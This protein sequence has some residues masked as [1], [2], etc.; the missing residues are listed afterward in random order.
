MAS[1]YAGSY[2]GEALEGRL[3]V[4]VS[5]IPTITADTGKVTITSN[6]YAEFPLKTWGGGATFDTN[7]SFDAAPVSVS[8]GSSSNRVT[9]WHLGTRVIEVTP[10]FD[11]PLS[12]AIQGTYTGVSGIGS[13]TV[14]S[15]NAWFSIPRKPY[16]AALP[17]L[18]FQY[19]RSGSSATLNWL[20]N[21]TGADG[22]HP[23]G[24]VRVSRWDNVGGWVDPI[25][26]LGWNAVTWTDTSLAADRAYQYG[27]R[28]EGPGGASAWVTPPTVLYTQPLAPTNVVA[29]K[30]AA[31]D[32]VVSWNS[33]S[34][35]ATRWEV[36][37]AADGV[38]EPDPIAAVTDKSW[39]HQGPSILQTHS[40]RIVALTPDD[41]NAS[42]PSASSGA[43]L[44]LAAPGA[45]TDLSPSGVVLNRSAAHT[46]TWRH[47]ARDSTPQTAYE[48]QSRVSTNGGSTWS[49]WTSAKVTSGA[50]SAGV[51][52]NAYTVNTMIQWQVRTWGSHATASG[53]SATHTYEVSATPA[54]T[55]TSPTWNQVISESL[56]SVSWNYSGSAIQASYVA[57]L[58]TAGNVIETRTGTGTS[59]SV[60]FNY[61]LS[62]NTS[63]IIELTVTDANGLASARTNR[64]FSVK[65]VGPPAARGVATWDG[66]LGSVTLTLTN[67]TPG[68]GVPQA[69]S[70]SVERL[71][72]GTWYPLGDYGL[73]ATL[74][75]P[76]P[77]VGEATYRLT[78]L[79]SLG[80][81][82]STQVTVPT[83][84]RGDWVWVNYGPHFGLRARVR[85]GVQTSSKVS[86]A[87][88]RHN[89]VGR[90]RAVSYFGDE[91]EFAVAVSGL[92]E[93][94]DTLGNRAAWYRASSEGDLVCYRDHLGRRL[95][96]ALSEVSFDEE[97]DDISS[98]VFDVQEDDYAE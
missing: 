80:G 44:L 68:A 61:R 97:S 55:I 18:N 42:A 73:D 27:V 70:T 46:R 26:T 82:T 24:G 9:R 30:T 65:F 45:P 2:A 32:I 6:W 1:T 17:P 19:S 39:T 93:E 20:G 31:G 79:S 74:T 8:I 88:T 66:E 7:G 84:N 34:T 87:R 62:N 36:Y 50:S 95:F 59:T 83:V 33:P 53:W 51:A 37:H 25:H 69:V 47:N 13:D 91:R 94:A 40:Y 41:L 63:Y 60:G 64:S 35:T 71:V 75:D 57:V 58:R 89:F 28:A 76:I 85:L 5:D 67:P 49:S 12:I 23:W 90:Q 48:I 15:I 21:Y 10:R 81:S 52:A 22:A 54:V 98:L 56:V 96:G 4:E 3:V 72:G 77:T 11:A 78:T 16:K 43:M 86:R 14:V 38:W 92:T 29:A